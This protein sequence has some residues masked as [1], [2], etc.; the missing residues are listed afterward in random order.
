MNF[1]A[2][3]LPQDLSYYTYTNI[4]NDVM[5]PSFRLSAVFI[6]CA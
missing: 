5:I 6:M 2:I 3:G 1:K 4:K